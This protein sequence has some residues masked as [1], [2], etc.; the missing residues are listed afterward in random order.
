MLWQDLPE[1]LPFDESLL[2]KLCNNAQINP[3]KLKNAINLLNILKRP[4]PVILTGL[5]AM[6]PNMTFDQLK[7]LKFIILTP[8]EMEMLKRKENL[9]QLEKFLIDLSSI[10][11]IEKRLEFINLVQ[12]FDQKIAN[13]ESILLQYTLAVTSLMSSPSL[14]QALGAVLKTGNY[15]N[16]GTKAGGAIGFS[17]ESL[18]QLNNQS[19]NIKD[20]TLMGYIASILS[21]KCPE[22]LNF[23][24]EFHE[25]IDLVINQK[26][27]IEKLVENV[28]QIYNLVTSLL[29]AVP[30][31]ETN[32]GDALAM[33]FTDFY[34]EKKDKIEAIH[35]TAEA[36]FKREEEAIKLLGGKK[37]QTLPELLHMLV[38]FERDLQNAH[39]RQSGLILGNQPGSPVK[40]DSK[41]KGFFGGIF[42]K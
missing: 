12:D 37:G 23:T 18:E 35:E 9:D 3:E 22:A 11:F 13:S 41:K 20:V 17:L 15:L 19:T 28:N 39:R 29:L 1:E 7:T 10:P 38:N 36:A 33:T 24:S 5:I 31:L 14:R 8:T 25:L 2:I 32:V 42:G 27:N 21:I 30:T 6:N 34:A 40:D 26:L 4:Y 16:G